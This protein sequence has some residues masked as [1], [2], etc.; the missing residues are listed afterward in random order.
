[1]AR[2]LAC[3]AVALFAAT[4][5]RGGE[6]DEE[7]GTNASS[8]STAAVNAV[9][10][11]GA[12][13]SA[14]PVLALEGHWKGSE[15]DNEMPSQSFHGG[16]GFGHGF[17]GFGGFGHGFGGFGAL[18]GG[19]GGFG[20]RRRRLRAWLRRLRRLRAWLRRARLRR[21]RLRRARLRWARLGWLARLGLGPAG[22][23]AGASGPAGVGAGSAG[24]GAGSAGAG[25]GVAMA[26]SASGMATV[27]A[28]DASSE[29][30]AREE[31]ARSPPCRRASC[32]G[33]RSLLRWPSWP[34]AGPGML[35]RGNPPPPLGSPTS[36][37]CGPGSGFPRNTRMPLGSGL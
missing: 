29:G 31:D 25:V 12:P 6:L 4:C 7:F 23:G 2:T 16:G 13:E 5:A 35:N 22:V 18:G 19:F 27:A 30:H 15:L 20:Q 26:G 28:G 14:S 33:K 32:V 24:A 37:M 3:L 21:A 11:A 36:R 9:L 34:A 8:S 1:M 10:P 17:G